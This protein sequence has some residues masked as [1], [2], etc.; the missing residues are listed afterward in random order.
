MQETRKDPPGREFLPRH[1]GIIMDG[2]GRWAKAR[3][4]PREL[5]HQAGSKVVGNIVRHCKKLGIPAI[6]VY[7]FST[8][9][10]KRP[11]KE[12]NALLELLRRFLSNMEE[13]QRENARL[14]VLGD[15][16]PLPPDLREAIVKAQEGSKDNTAITVNIALNYGG[17][18]EILHSVKALA[19]DCA[20]GALDPETTRS[21]LRLL[22]EVN[23]TLGITIVVITHEMQVVKE[24]C[25]Q[26]YVMEDGRV[27]EQ[28]DVFQIF[29]S[30]QQAITRRF[31]DSASNLSHIQEL[32]DDPARPIKLNPGDYLLRLNYLKRSTSEALI[33]TLSR[34]FEL[35]INILFGNIEL[36][37]GNPLGGLVVIAGGGHDKVTAAT[38]YLSQRN[39]LVEVISHG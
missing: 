31:V 38:G 29:A 4:L 5:G 35:D 10:W 9:N 7:A 32:L 33:S 14:R 15:P 24:I 34:H 17:R 6:T 2:N 37:D 39:V 12:V 28:G 22:K 21:I 23:R 25:H 19:R 20:A 30:P 36:I 13:Y 11:Q 27:V 26:V 1:V 8:E 16:S 3:S 18:A